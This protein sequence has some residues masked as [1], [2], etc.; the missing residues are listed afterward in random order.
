MSKASVIL[1]ITVG[2]LVLFLVS[3]SPK[4]KTDHDHHHHGGGHNQHHRLKL[5]SSFNFKP[6]RHD[7]IPFDPLVADMERRRDDKEWERQHVDHSH[8][9]LATHDPAP[10]H[11]SQP[12][13]EDF[14]DAEDYLNDEEKFNVTDRLISLFPKLDVSPTD[15]FV[16][17]S[18]LTEWNMQ[19]SAKEVM[20]R[21]QRDMDVHDRNNDGFISFSEYE[22]PSWVRNSGELTRVC[23]LLAIF[24]QDLLDE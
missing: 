7:P 6:T 8:P 4:N 11:E 9:E 13:W 3:Y 24:M 17:E 2:I 1:Y 10:G 22:P 23:V 21:T 18:E 14:M 5:R 20:H 16:T 15:G 19:S 12:E